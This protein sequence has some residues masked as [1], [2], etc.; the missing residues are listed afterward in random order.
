[1]KPE[2]AARRFPG[3]LLGLACL[4]LVTPLGAAAPDREVV[5]TNGDA[6]PVRVQPVGTTTVTLD[7]LAGPLDVESRALGALS[8]TNPA[9][10]KVVASDGHV[11]AWS[12]KLPAAP[13]GHVRVWQQVSAILTTPTACV[14]DVALWIQGTSGPASLFYLN[15][16]L[17][18]QHPGSDTYTINE[19]VVVY[20][21]GG[22]LASGGEEAYLFLN[23]NCVDGHAQMSWSVSGRLLPCR[24]PDCE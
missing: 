4:T 19:Q 5:V 8:A 18:R 23:K 22:E 21:R 1:M 14:P 16:R 12:T 13:V 10:L 11:H 7:P 2:L 17:V 20:Q 9:G 6:N 3:A 24:S 15:P